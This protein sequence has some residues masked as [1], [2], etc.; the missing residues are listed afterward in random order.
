MNIADDE[1]RDMDSDDH[2]DLITDE[3]DEIITGETDEIITGETDDDDIDVTAGISALGVEKI[4]ES[5]FV[6]D[7]NKLVRY[8]GVG[9]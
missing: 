3:T 8:T 1:F 7:G 6:V 9:E 2:D 5:G 4:L